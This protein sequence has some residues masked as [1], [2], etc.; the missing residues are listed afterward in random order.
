LSALSL[1]LR[2]SFTET[3]RAE[4][5]ESVTYTIA[6][7]DD[8]IRRCCGDRADFLIRSSGRVI[9]HHRACFEAF[10]DESTGPH[11]DVLRKAAKDLS[12][13]GCYHPVDGVWPEE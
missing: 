10:L 2:A 5:T 9:S 11:I 8:A 13:T 12:R 1:R 6:Q 3:R 7:L 4:M